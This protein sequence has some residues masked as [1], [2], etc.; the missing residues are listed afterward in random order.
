M[1]FLDHRMTP[2]E[3]WK[4][5]YHRLQIALRHRQR[6]F[7]PD[8]Q[9]TEGWPWFNPDSSHV[10]LQIH[11]PMWMAALEASYIQP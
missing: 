8:C 5:L 7:N 6:G 1:C 3:A 10:T 9:M 2:K 4:V 11:P